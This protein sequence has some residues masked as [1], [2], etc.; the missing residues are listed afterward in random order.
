MRFRGRLRDT[1]AFIHLPACVIHGPVANLRIKLTD[2]ACKERCRQG[3]IASDDKGRNQI[4]CSRDKRK[5]D[6]DNGDGAVCLR[7]RAGMIMARCQQPADN[8]SAHGQPHFEHKQRTGETYTGEVPA[9]LPF[10]VVHRIAHHDPLYRQ[11]QLV[12]ESDD[13]NK[14]KHY[15]GHVHGQEEHGHADNKECDI[16]PE[17]NP[18]FAHFIRNGFCDAASQHVPDAI[19]TQEPGEYG[20]I[21]DIVPASKGAACVLFTLA[22][23]VV[24]GND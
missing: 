15:R 22:G 9:V 13:K 11:S 5:H 3:V 6:V 12:E 23:R 4:A 24:L 17:I 20:R 14:P 18:H 1:P 8:C 19:R 16:A 21:P 7:L 2:N 10:P